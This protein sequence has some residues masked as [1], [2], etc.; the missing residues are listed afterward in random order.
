MTKTGMR[1]SNRDG[2]RNGKRIQ[3]LCAREQ[4]GTLSAGGGSFLGPHA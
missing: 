3:I 2:N 1:G 4:E